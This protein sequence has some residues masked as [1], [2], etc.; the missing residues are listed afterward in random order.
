MRRIQQDE[1]EDRLEL[2][3][4]G[5]VMMSVREY[6]RA[7][8]ISSPQL[9]YYYIRR[10]RIEEQS[11]PCCGRKVINIKQADEVFLKDKDKQ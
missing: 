1:V 9:V 7:R 11:C 2:A 8:R 10:G 5:I 4:Q 6:T 3:Q